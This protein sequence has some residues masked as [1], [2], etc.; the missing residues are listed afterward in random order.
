MR[1]TV[2]IQKTNE[3]LIVS[4]PYN[5]QLPGLAKNIGGRWSSEH[6]AWIFDIRTEHEVAKIYRTV[7]GQYN[8]TPDCVT[9]KCYVT[10]AAYKRCGGLELHGIPIAAA[11]GRDSGARPC[12]GVVLLEG[13]IVSAG[14]VKNWETRALPG[15]VFTVYDVQRQVA[16]SLVSDP[17]WCGK[18]E[19]I[20]EP[21]NTPVE[22]N[23]P[24]T[25]SMI[26]TINDKIKLATRDQLL[27]ILN[28]LK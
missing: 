13:K 27:V 7:Y 3:Q 11:L 28:I 15:T 17:E 8:E 22:T 2:K 14:S 20:E 18:I 12:D 6:K 19:I 10:E 21:K 5:S 26:D 1:Q 25:A 23:E 16:E 24:T 4:S 9:I